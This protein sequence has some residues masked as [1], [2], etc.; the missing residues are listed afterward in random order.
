MQHEMLAK[1]AEAGISV[2]ACLNKEMIRFHISTIMAV[3]FSGGT[4]FFR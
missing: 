2:N 3:F 1:S 4:S